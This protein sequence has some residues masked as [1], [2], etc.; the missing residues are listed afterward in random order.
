MDTVADD[1]GEGSPGAAT[2]SNCGAVQGGE[3]TVHGNGNLGP[4][5]R[6]GEGRAGKALHTEALCT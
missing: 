3:T 5:L 2:G 6:E 4:S 1:G